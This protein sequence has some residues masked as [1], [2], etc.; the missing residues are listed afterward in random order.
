MARFEEAKADIAAMFRREDMVRSIKETGALPSITDALDAIN[1]W[2]MDDY[3]VD[4]E[5]LAVSAYLRM[6]ADF[7]LD[8]PEE[9]REAME[10][11]AQSHVI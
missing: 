1:V 3:G 5:T 4:V 2:V 8:Y 9:C 6:I 7:V 10:D 11:F